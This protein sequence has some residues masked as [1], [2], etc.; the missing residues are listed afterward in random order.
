MFSIFST[1]TCA[2][3]LSNGGRLAVRQA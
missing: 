2:H 3:S 1:K